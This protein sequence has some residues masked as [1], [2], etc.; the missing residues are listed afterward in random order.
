MRA[1]R[2]KTTVP[3]NNTLQLNFLALRPGE[4]VEIIILALE[5][6]PN[7]TDRVP[8]ETST[9][10]FVVEVPQQRTM[11]GPPPLAVPSNQI[12]RQAALAAIQ[13]S[14]YAQSLGPGEPLASD[15]FATR[16]AEEKA[17]EERHWLP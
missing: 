11:P 1:Y 17:R 6:V 8:K 14:K 7:R 13:S 4:T 2:L 9:E 5:D 12:Q 15:I 16:K 10:D 3:D